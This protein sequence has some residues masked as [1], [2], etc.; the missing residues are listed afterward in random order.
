MIIIWIGNYNII[1]YILRLKGYEQIPT[2]TTNFTE[3]E[4][5]ILGDYRLA[6]DLVIPSTEDVELFF[7]IVEKLFKEIRAA[8]RI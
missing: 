5:I 1:V 3:G 7:Y 6:K 4:D 2:A 8:D